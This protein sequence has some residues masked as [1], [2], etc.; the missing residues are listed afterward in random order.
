MR[1]AARD[2]HGDLS[3][4]A[5]TCSVDRNGAPDIPAPTSLFADRPQSFVSHGFVR[6]ILE[7][8]NV[9]AF[10]VGCRR[11][12][13]PEEDADPTV[14]SPLGEREGRSDID[15]GVGYVGGDFDRLSPDHRHRASGCNEVGLSDAVARPF[16][17][18]TRVGKRC[19]LVIICTGAQR[20]P[21]VGLVE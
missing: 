19:D 6:L 13:R 8:E 7:G 1:R 14:L 18:Y 21:Q 16:R 10:G 12:H 15:G 5:S 3:E 11:P 2:H 17:R 20:A 9:T 4:R